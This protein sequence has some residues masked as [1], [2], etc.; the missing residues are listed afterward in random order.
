MSSLFRP[1]LWTYRLC[2]I[3]QRVIKN[4]LQNK[5]K[6]HAR[7]HRGILNFPIS[8]NKKFETQYFWH[9]A[10]EIVE[11]VHTTVRM[12]NI[13]EKCYCCVIFGISFVGSW[14]NLNITVFLSP[15]L[16]RLVYN[17]SLSLSC[18]PC[19]KFRYRVNLVDPLFL[20]KGSQKD[21]RVSQQ[22]NSV[23]QLS[24]TLFCTLSQRSDRRENA[25]NEECIFEWTTL[26]ERDRNRMA[27]RKK[28]CLLLVCLCP[29]LQPEKSCWGFTALWRRAERREACSLRLIPSCKKAS[30]YRLSFDKALNSTSERLYARREQIKWHIIKT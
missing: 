2:S 23:M 5:I 13:N 25:R 12:E 3:I 14:N 19:S 24:L 27:R 28:S 18:C 6:V 11:I 9:V 17:S 20:I 1:N 10:I 22:Q 29:N 8:V 15:L 21:S 7:Y 16:I 26:E 4:N 30:C